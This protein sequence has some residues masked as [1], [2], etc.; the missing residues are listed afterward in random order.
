MSGEVFPLMD[1]QRE[2]VNPLESVWLSASAG[3]GKTQVLSARVL[4]LLLQERVN[5]DEILCLTFTK[6]GAAE[7]AVRINQVLARW[8]RLPETVLAKEL[9]FIGAKG[10]PKTI[11]KARTLFA[12]VLDCPGGGLRIDTIH[13]FAQW[14]LANFPSEAGIAPG[15]RAME[16]RERDLLSREVLGELLAD[17]EARGDTELLGAA[18]EF[19]RRKG[20][21]EVRSWVMRCAGEM[22]LW[23]DKG[24]LTPPFRPRIFQLIGAPS[25]ADQD[26]VDAAL[27]PAEFPDDTL[28]AM[29]PTFQAWKTKGG[30]K[31]S[32]AISTWLSAAPSDRPSLLD[33]LAKSFLKVDGEP[34]ALKKPREMDP[35]LTGY[36]EEVAAAI[37]E[38]RERAVMLDLGQFL[39]AALT[40]GR[41]FALR[42]DDA[43]TREGLLD[44]DDLIRLAARLLKSS[45]SSDWIRFKLDREFDHILVD[46]AQD[47]NQPQWD[48]FDALIDDFFS[49]EGA[50]T[51]KLRTVFTVG[52]YKQA[53]FGFQGT[54][55]ENFEAA[56]QRV[57]AAMGTLVENAAKARRNS[58]LKE[59]RELDLGQ[60][61]RTSASVLS[62]VDGVIDGLG[63]EALGLK[64]PS[65]KHSGE[66]RAGLV[67]LWNPVRDETD[68]SDEAEREGSD[69]EN[70]LARH[71]R[72][73][74]DKIAEQVWRWTKGNA[75]FVLEK[76]VKQGKPPRH[77]TPGDIMVLV[78]SR[79]ELAGLIVARL[80]TRGVPVAGVDRLRLGAPLAVKDL[81][82]GLRFAA[83]PLDNLNLANLLVSPLIGWTQDELLKFAPREEKASLWEHLQK[84]TN[85]MVAASVD[86]LSDLL[87]KADFETP[88]SILN[89]MLVG[90]WRGR[91]KLLARLGYE[92]SDP[93]NELLNEAFH[94]EAAHTP[95]LAGFI[96]WFDA[97]EG[98]LK[99]DPG[100]A[101]DLVRVMTVHGSKGLQAPIVILADATS[102][103]G[104]A[105]DLELEE[106]QPRESKLPPVPVPSLKAELRAGRVEEAHEKAVADALREH[107]RLLYVAMTRAEEALFIGG[108]LSKRMSDKPPHEDSWYSRVEPLFGDNALEDDL[109]GARRELGRLAEPIVRAD[110]VAR[111]DA[112]EA[113]PQWALQPAKAEARPSKPLAPSGA[114]EN[115]DTQPP[116]PLDASA[117]AAR[118]GVLIHALLERLPYVERA[119]RDEAAKGWL[120]KQAR[121]L[122]QTMREEMREQALS[123]LDDA[124]FADIFGPD[125]LPEV[126]LSARVG[127]EVIAGLADRLLITKESVAVVDFKTTRRPPSMLEEIP[128]STLKQMAAYVAALEV[129]YPQHKVRAGVL[130]TQTPQLFALPSATL[131]EHKAG[132]HS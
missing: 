70:W 55:P 71:D 117:H 127:G 118:R 6:A 87:N 48:I 10:D 38:A 115:D 74:A 40:L 98:E 120:A 100:E 30:E 132:F 41:A 91:S 33:E 46:E 82:A 2:A 130:Y 68:S 7:M 12:S 81:M 8:V 11:A 89:W 24:S 111:G 36:V 52:D 35:N 39:S 32:L 26:W 125:A 13:A 42:F 129:I 107:W 102:K 128:L 76:G 99:R 60:S 23:T 119:N 57:K 93:I 121:D 21:D 19:S 34:Q 114:G 94:Y 77:A 116:M 3:T 78:R 27:S 37:A 69:A 124:E 103:P 61:F 65:E 31:A 131:E 28:A 104:S 20:P 86:A 9:G 88:E 58:Q 92:A 112:D 110:D 43:K 83:Q 18:A 45:T 122:P 22:G 44:F 101:S 17:A 14:L 123:V 72:K 95:S 5:P 73:M 15:S 47:T 66:D 16:D 63:Y 108:S 79:K 106:E 49:G 1:N 4:R 62:F 96:R 29:L 75:P 67:T 113:L 53:I 80:H 54:S 97:G 25:D 51:G 90:P 126:P 109:W 59:L 50:S 84:Q 85:S 105:G 64:Q 56:K